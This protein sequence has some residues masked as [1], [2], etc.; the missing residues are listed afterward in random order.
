MEVLRAP[1]T[2][3][4]MQEA[5]E[6][7]LSGEPIGEVL[8][9]LPAEVWADQHKHAVMQ[10]VF[11]NGEHEWG[12][13]IERRHHEAFAKDCADRMYS[14]DVP[15]MRRVTAM[16]VFT[17]IERVAEWALENP[18][19]RGMASK[20]IAAIYAKHFPDLDIGPEARNN[21]EFWKAEWL[22]HPQ[23]IDRRQVDLPLECLRHFEEAK[24]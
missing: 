3:D 4:E 9:S 12:L 6:R 23:Y 15:P 17:M 13:E 18:N 1:M 19:Y 8:D 22:V 20:D 14:E 5:L 16:L 21:H 11:E 10:A 24:T 7:A 2:V